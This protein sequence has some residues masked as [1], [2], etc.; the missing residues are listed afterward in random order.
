MAA[1]PWIRTAGIVSA[2]QAGE[3]LDV[4]LPWRRSAQTARTMKEVRSPVTGRINVIKFKWDAYGKVYVNITYIFV[5][6]NQV[7]YVTL[8]ETVK[9]ACLIVYETTDIL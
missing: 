6:D 2:N 3:G 8:V 4:T 1:V 5:N 7:K 9:C